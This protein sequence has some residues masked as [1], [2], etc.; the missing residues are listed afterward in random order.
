MFSVVTHYQHIGSRVKFLDTHGR[1]RGNSKYAAPHIAYDPVITLYNPYDVALELDK[2]RVR[3]WDPPV[4]FGFKKNDVWMR[5]EFGRGE[6][7]GLGRFHWTSEKNP[8]ARKYFT[9]LL[10]EIGSSASPGRAIRM[11]P[12]EVRVFSP[13]VESNWTWGLETRDEWAPRAF[14]DWNQNSDFGNRDNRTGNP[15]GIEAVAG[16]DPRAGLQTDH[17]SYIGKP[18][19][20]RYDFEIEQNYENSGWVNIKVDDTFSVF[21]RPGRAVGESAGDVPDFAVDLLAAV[22]EQTQSD[23]LRSYEMRFENVSRELGEGFPRAGISRTFQ[24]GDLVQAPRDRS[25]GGK[26]PFAI[27]TMSA[28]STVDPKDASK[29]WLHNHPVISGVAQD[30]AKVGNALSTYDLRLEEVADFNTFPGIELDP[31]TNRGF[32]GASVT[33]NRGVSNV[34]MFRV[35][36]MPAASLGDLIPWNLVSGS[37]LPH[38]TRTLGYSAAH[39]LLPA[40]KISAAPQGGSAQAEMLDH[41][42]L[43]NHKLWDS[44]FFSTVANFKSPLVSSM[45]RARLLEDFVS[46]KSVLLNPRFVPLNSGPVAK[47]DKLSDS[48]F[49]KQIASVMGVAGG[50]NVNCDDV[51]VWRAILSSLRDEAVLG[52]GSTEHSSDSKTAFPRMSFSLAGDADLQN[53]GSA[54]VLGQ[55]RWAGFRALNDKKIETLAQEIVEQLRERARKDRAPS[56]SLGE[57]VNRRIG[58]AGQLHALRG[59]LGVAI[60]ESGVN[61]RY[62]AED[63]KEI[64]GNE[65]LMAT[66]LNGLV[67]PNARL[68]FTGDGAPSILTEGDLLMALAPIVQ[69]RGDTFKIR[70]YGESRDGSGRVLATARCEAVVQRMPDYLDSTDESW[71]DQNSL[72]SEVN[73]R[74]GRRFEL[75]SFKWL[76]NEEI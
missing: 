2:L 7:H 60:A 28:K 76:S 48:D 47:I 16:W 1:P 35:P 55:V 67:E 66:D 56:L 25:P 43:M 51:A 44:Y 33:A 61:D 10:S 54:D 5:P 42:Y 74:F 9:L 27:L 23:I 53:S 75:V 32:Y 70:A 45:P 13:W 20:L 62:H 24:V 72:Q 50:F 36:V 31:E 46:G 6:F 8:N 49:A 18:N 68:G 64:T 30:T 40:S 39:P 21:A 69:V 29:P 52:W 4:L 12:G 58:P 59:A 71:Q 41:C 14:F 11:E 17:I 19:S 34:P 37:S 73:Q 65:R 15:F 63:S 57:L 22:N 26:T 38:F 3:I